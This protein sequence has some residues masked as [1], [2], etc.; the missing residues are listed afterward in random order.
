MKTSPLY[1]IAETGAASSTASTNMG[2]LVNN[3]VKA[4]HSK[5]ALADY[6]T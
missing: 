2:Q 5:L 4:G 3:T 6:R 1:T